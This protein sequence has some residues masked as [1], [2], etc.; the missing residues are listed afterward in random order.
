[1]KFRKILS[2]IIT[3]IVVSSTVLIGCNSSNGQSTNTSSDSNQTTADNQTNQ[4]TQSSSGEDKLDADQTLNLFY[5][6]PLTL[7]VND[8]RNAT[9]FQIMTQVF[10]GL[11]RVLVDKDGKEVIEPAGAESYDVSPDGLVWTFKLRD[12][13]WSDGVKVTAQQ[14]VDSILRLLDP[15]K[16]F[17][18]A[19]YAFD[20]L[21]AEKFY[22]KEASA[23]DIGIKAKDDRTLEITLGKPTPQFEKKIGFACMFP[24]RKDL[25]D[26]GG[27]TYAT[28]FKAHAYN[29]P[30]IIK[31]WIKDNSMTLEKSSTY[32]D[33]ANVHLQTVNLNVVPEFSTKAQLFESKQA[34]LIEGNQDYSQKWIDMSKNGDIQ[35]KVGKYPSMSFIAFNHQTGG[36]SG[37]M[38]NTKI[39][40]ALSLS[41]DRDEFVKTI[42]NRYY[43]GYGLYPYGIDIGDKEFR[44]LYDEPLKAE[45]EKY[46]KDGAKLQELFK[47]GLK[48][49][50]VDK[51][52]SDITLVY[53][54]AASSVIEKSAAEYLQQSWQNKLGIKIE[55]QQYDSKTF[56][57][58]RNNAEFDIILMGWHGDYNDPMTFAD[59]W[60]STGGFIKY[61]GWYS[62]P[63]YDAAFSKL[64]GVTDLNERAEIYEELEKQATVTDVGIA[65]IYYND[66]VY[67]EQNYV[68][69]LS[70]LMFGPQVD[71]SRAYI[72]GK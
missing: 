45:Y 21:N 39:K 54:T 55:L 5:D 65:P 28:D 30:F 53:I 58:K 2:L 26:K 46:N 15:D 49:L 42:Y 41:I 29:G 67:F 60:L 18:Y 7:D 8:A 13:S 48:E 11:V 62:S 66:N 69:N 22:N 52:L 23:Q 12:H 36:F 37:I 32:W 43:P 56:R 25:I 64:D 33:A 3:G 27:D 1:M 47:E 20:I 31:D 61:F 72:S 35:Y 6:D 50:N 9:E 57:D 44:S 70:I 16:A 17:S 38:K 51:Q 19:F 68:K 4:P 10:E 34:D 71:F 63:E 40:M 24:I 14:Y 59:I